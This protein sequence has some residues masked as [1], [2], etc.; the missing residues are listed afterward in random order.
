MRPKPVTG[1]GWNLLSTTVGFL[2]LWKGIQWALLPS[3]EPTFLGLY[4]SSKTVAIFVTVS[5]GLLLC[6]RKTV[7]FFSEKWKFALPD[8]QAWNLS[9]WNSQR[10]FLCVWII[11]A[12]SSLVRPFSLGDDFSNLLQS[13]KQYQNGTTEVFNTGAS[14][15][16]EDLSS[17]DINHGFWY[18]PGPLYLIHFIS[19]FGLS[20]A[21]ATRLSVFLASLSAGI[22]TLKVLEELGISSRARLILGLTFGIS[23]GA[24][25]SGIGSSDL[26]GLAILPW[27]F[28]GALRL[29][30]KLGEQD[31]SC[32]RVSSL[33]A[34]IGLV[35]GVVYWFKYSHFVFS[36]ACALF[37]GL[38]LLRWRR[39]W[40]DR[41]VTFIILCTSFALPPLLL[42]HWQATTG[43]GSTALAYSE[44]SI[45]DHGYTLMQYGEH[46]L[47]TSRGWWLGACLLFGGGWLYLPHGHF[48]V[49]AKYIAFGSV[50]DFLYTTLGINGL[51]LL[52]LFLSFALCFLLLKILRYSVEGRP[53]HIQRFVWIVWPVSLWLLCIVGYQKGWSYVLAEHNRFGGPLLFLS[54]GI[55]I[56]WAISKKT[57]STLKK[58]IIFLLVAFPWFSQ[59]EGLTRRLVDGY[60]GRIHLGGSHFGANGLGSDPDRIVDQINALIQNP[61]DLIFITASANEDAIIFGRNGSTMNMKGRIYHQWRL[62]QVYELDDG[63]FRTSQSCRIVFLHPTIHG[64]FANFWAQAKSKFEGYRKLVK[65][66][67]QEGDRV[68]IAYLELE[69]TPI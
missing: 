20:L 46:Y 57:S 4:S 43:M 56:H 66:P 22:G 44:A 7:Q 47:A 15:R 51:M 41:L 42:H 11:L 9:W 32:K 67:L 19:F 29:A 45:T 53:T 60:D 36:C 34:R 35:G 38:E 10:I 48:A 3:K 64:P 63:Y 16:S 5:I 37:L 17:S 33:V 39:S 30:R 23:I 58:L 12:T 59:V 25:F 69:P 54:V 13:L 8:P 2:F 55:L 50:H 52:H 28:L 40:P 68:E 14:P 49:L 21:D 1:E 24:N 6:S 26:F 62:E 18:P 31:T 61:E 65:I 27:M